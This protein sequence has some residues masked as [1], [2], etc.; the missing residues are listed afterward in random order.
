[1]GNPQQIREVL[2]ELVSNARQAMSEDGGS[3]VI[4]VS[5]GTGRRDV[6]G[7]GSPGDCVRIEV[8]DTG[9]GIPA[10]NL[11]RVFDPFFTTRD[12][13]QGYGLGLS[14]AH[15]IVRAHGGE[16][17]IESPASGGT[18]VVLF[19]PVSG[20]AAE[21]ADV[22]TDEPDP[23][24]LVV[25]DEPAIVSMTRKCLVRRGYVVRTAPDGDSALTTLRD[26]PGEPLLLITDLSMPGMS[27]E[28]LVA[29]AR[30]DHRDLR[31]LVMSGYGPSLDLDR[32]GG[33]TLTSVLSK[34]FRAAELEAAI[35]AI[36]PSTASL[37]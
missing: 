1:V 37:R 21:G 3:I 17:R 36:F 27:G 6:D 20:A 24:V 14:V 10:R 13:G 34:P 5:P 18:R 31:V 19:L 23:Y 30:A 16:I 8:L 29:K 9:C 4:S 7:P 25:D 33:A 11:P 28:E 22:T 26:T 35:G 12:V 32:F 2:V 15:G